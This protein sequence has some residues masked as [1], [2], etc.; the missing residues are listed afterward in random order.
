MD[1]EESGGGQIEV[2][3]RHLL[4]GTEETTKGLSHVSRTLRRDLYPGPL[5]Y[6]A[7]RSVG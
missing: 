7:G 3:T 1:L 5:E 4:G 2:T 6:E